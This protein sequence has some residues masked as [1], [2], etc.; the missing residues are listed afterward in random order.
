MIL[1]FEGK[2][3]VIDPSAFVANNATL[4]GNVILSEQTS[5]WFGA[6]LRADKNV[7]QIGTRSNIQDI[8]VLH[9]DEQHSIAIGKGVTVGHRAILHGCTLGDDVLVGMGAIIMNGADIGDASLI[10]A[11]ALVPEGMKVP[12][13]SLVMGMP[14]RVKR[15]LTDQEVQSLTANAEHYV[16]AAQR[17]LKL[18]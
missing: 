15:T 4:V 5:V 18:K 9:V 17:Y 8:S 12:P 13:R 14:A 3:P 1:P 7:I 16:K 6:V 10:A 2:N 11:G